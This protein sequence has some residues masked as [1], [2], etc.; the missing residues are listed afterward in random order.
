MT[1]AS[2]AALTIYD[3]VKGVERGVEIQ[4]VRLVSKT[5][6]KSGDVGAP[7]ARR[8]R[9][10]TARGRARAPASPAGSGRSA[11]AASDRPMTDRAG[12]LG[13]RPHRERRRRGRRPRRHLGRAGSRSG[14]R[15][16]ASES[17]AALVPD[18]QWAIE[19]ALVDGAAAHD[20]VVTTGGTG[21]TPRD[22][23]PQATQAVVDYEVPGLAEAMRAAGR[24][25]DAAGGPVARRRRRP[26]PAASSSTCPAARRAPSNRSR[27]SCP[28]STTR[29]RR[30]PARTIT[31][32][33]A[34]GGRR[35]VAD[36]MFEPFADVPAYPLVFPSSGARPRSSCSRWPGAC[37]SSRP[38]APTARA[39]RRASR[40]ALVGPRPSTPSSRPRCSATPGRR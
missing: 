13:P 1:A 20:L 21:L 10:S 33:T 9:P 26:R 35:R 37:G 14:W 27:R 22:V 31:R 29:S 5:G 16:S 38:S 24:A 18:E 7:G 30:S 3:M 40:R 4:G 15:P 25:V 23:T 8:T 32:I 11:R 28:C 36:P 6:G 19:E 39:V 12:A 2:V 34:P 17:S